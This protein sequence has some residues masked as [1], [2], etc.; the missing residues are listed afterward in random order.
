MSDDNLPISN[1]RS[2]RNAPEDK[3]IKSIESN[4]SFLDIFI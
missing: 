1:A 2:A 4:I 3:S